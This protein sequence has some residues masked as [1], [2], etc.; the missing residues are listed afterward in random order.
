FAVGFL[1][2][3]FGVDA[4]RALQQ[5][6]VQIENVARIC[7][8]ARRTAQQQRNLAIRPGLL[9]EIIVDDQRVFAAVAE[10]LAHRA[11]GVRRDVLHRGRIGRRGRD[12]DGVLQR[13]EFFQLAHYVGDR[14]LLLADRDVDAFDAGTALVDDRVHRQRGLAGLA[15]ADD[16][17]AL[18]AA[19]RDHRV[20]RLVTG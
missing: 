18:A 1:L 13:A 10:E 12:D 16:Q 5:A 7:L 8:A 11:T 15:I 6:R 14:A 9:S 4:R 2:D 17:L 20:H 19:D 3:V